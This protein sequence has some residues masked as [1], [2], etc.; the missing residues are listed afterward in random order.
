MIFESHADDF[1]GKVD[2]DFDQALEDAAE[3]AAALPGSPSD[4]HAEH[5]GRLRGRI[6]SDKAYAKA[7]ERGA[8]ITPKK[9]RR[10]RNG[11]PAALRSSSGR[12]Y[13]R[14]RIPAQRYLAKTGKEWGRILPARLRR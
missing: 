14:V 5:T 12:F 13:K 11:R 3:H 6:G 9:G 7:Q 8:F 2:R 4:L 10:G 1:L